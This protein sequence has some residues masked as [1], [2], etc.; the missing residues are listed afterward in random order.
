MIYINA[1]FAEV[2]ISLESF[3]SYKMKFINE[4]LFIGGLYI[5][6]LY[7]NNGNS[8]G[9]YYSA[10]GDSKSLLLIGYILWN[11][12]IMAINIVSSNIESETTRGT[13]EQKL[14]SIIPLYILLFGK[15][16]SAILNEFLE[17]SFI[18]IIS[19]LFF[20]INITI[21]LMSIII[22]FVT[23][24]GMYGIGLIF[25]GLTLRYK[26]IGRII[27]L[28]QTLLLFISDT[29]MIVSDKLSI[30]NLIPLTKGTD[31]IRRSLVGQAIPFSQLL[32]LFL[33]SILWLSIGII[34]FNF[35]KKLS[36]IDGLIGSY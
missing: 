25:G 9:T 2:K 13:L 7:M 23:I 31:L 1:L 22:L 27:Y 11:F 10:P 12:S 19:F 34:T 21:N 8:L 33:I 29:L 20:K 30:I 18:L 3:L 17:V 35:F 16:I 32:F 14:T 26:Q 6:L 4:V 15:L 24:I 5:C 28:T 36:K